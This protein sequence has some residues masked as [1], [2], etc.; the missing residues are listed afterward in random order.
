MKKKILSVASKM[1]GLL[2]CSFII[3]AVAAGSVTNGDNIISFIIIGLSLMVLSLIVLFFKG[4]VGQQ[5]K[6]FYHVVFPDS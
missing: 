6:N 4:V 3:A 2:G 5:P 1:L